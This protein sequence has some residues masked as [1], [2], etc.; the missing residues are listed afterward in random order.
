MATAPRLA[1][2]LLFGCAIAFPQLFQPVLDDA[3]AYLL[4]SSIY[5]SSTFETFWTVIVY[6]IAEGSYI[7]RFIHYPQLRLANLKKVAEGHKPIPKLQRPKNRVR[8]GFTYIAPLLLMDLTMI[9]KFGGVS[10]RDMA[11][12]GNYDPNTLSIRGNFLAPTLHHF[13][14]HSPLQTQRAL[15]PLPP[16][17]RQL[18][19]QLAASILIYDTAFFFFHLALH[20]LPYVSRIHNIHHKHGEINPQVT[21]QLGIGERLGLVLLANFSL[22]IIK[23]HV[24]TRTLFVPMFVW[25][26]VDIHSGMDHPWGYDKILPQGWAAGSKRHAAHHQYG[27]KY[28]E[29]FF[30][31]WDD[32]YEWVT[33]RRQAEDP[34]AS[35]CP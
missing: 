33:T 28:Y 34:S 6:A 8:E 31:W 24:M 5:R 27:Q 10:V 20:K 3:Y 30:N 4:S 35:K 22:N 16:T 21:N 9:K 15:P 1:L 25:L 11:I 17:S 7:Y 19:V 12:S 13:T 26:L 2:G 18:V 14:L 29:P 32:A 23:S